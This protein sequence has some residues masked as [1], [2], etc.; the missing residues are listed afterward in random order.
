MSN[1]SCQNPA[2][3]NASQMLHALG[4][5]AYITDLDRRIVYWNPMAERITGWPAEAVIGRRCRDRILSHVD[6]DGHPLCGQESCPLHRCM[7]TGKPSQEPQ[8]LFAGN[9]AGDRVPVQVSVSPLID[10]QGQVIGG[11]EVFRDASQSLLDM[12]RAKQIQEQALDCQLIPDSRITFHSLYRARDFVG[13]D[14]FKIERLDEDHYAV[15]LADVVGHGVAAAL[16][17]MQ[18]SSLW[19]SLPQDRLS[20][21]RFLAQINSRLYPLTRD[22][23]YF[24]TAVYAVINALSGQ[25]RAACAG[26]PT[27]ILFRASGAAA[28]FHAPGEPLGMLP[29][30][31]YEGTSARLEPGDA[32][33]LFSDGAT[34]ICDAHGLALGSTG[35]REFLQKRRHRGALGASCLKHVEQDLLSYSNRIQLADDLTLILI[36]WNGVQTPNWVQ[37]RKSQFSPIAASEPSMTTVSAAELLV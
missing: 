36:Q 13:G 3:L 4:D 21:V 14:F 11:L 12:I 7:V 26:H 16:N 28:S 17:M 1:P 37:Q 32:L 6:K 31:D 18:L 10:G 35:L 23:G 8:M 2:L 9:H 24:G 15:C 5:G 30:P 27:P 25:V 34:E 19:E 33:L 20:P 29:D 22:T